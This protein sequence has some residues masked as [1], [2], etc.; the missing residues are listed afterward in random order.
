M[1]TPLARRLRW[2]LAREVVSLDDL[3]R[4]C[5]VLG[6]GLAE[7]FGGLLSSARIALEATI[8][9]PRHVAALALAGWYLTVPPYDGTRNNPDAPLAEWT[10]YSTFESAQDC[11]AE[12]N[13]VYSRVRNG[14]D[15]SDRMIE[16]QLF[17]A[18][19][20]STDDPSLE[21]N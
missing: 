18:K 8:M 11:E 1:I 20:I 19:S 21:G 12:K 4:G 13:D 17:D 3:S 14:E 10:V 15:E 9:K 2:K 7:A 5:A 6:I 16:R